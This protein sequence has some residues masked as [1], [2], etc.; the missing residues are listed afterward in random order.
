MARR[1]LSPE[2]TANFAGFLNGLDL[3]QLSERFDPEAM[4][5]AEVNSADHADPDAAAKRQGLLIW[6]S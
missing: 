3:A 1:A 6:M 4:R 5:R 2:E